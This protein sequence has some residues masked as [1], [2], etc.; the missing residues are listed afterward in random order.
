M[1]WRPATLPYQLAA[2]WARQGLHVLMLHGYE[3]RQGDIRLHSKR[4]KERKAAEASSQAHPGP[5][6]TV[7]LPHDV[8]KG[9]GQLVEQR[10]P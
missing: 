8:A 6:S 2:A 1:R 9:Q 3:P 7:L 10:T 4:A 5:R